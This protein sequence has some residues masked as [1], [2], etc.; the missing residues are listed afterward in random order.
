MTKS[1]VRSEVE[2]L[3]D[4][5]E[6]TA[7]AGY[8]FAIAYICHRDNMVMYQEKLDPADMSRLFTHERL[9]R[10]E[11]TTLLG[12]MVRRPLDLS[13]PTEKQLDALVERTDAL[14]AELH[15]VLTLPM[16]EPIMAQ[17]GSNSREPVG[18]DGAAMREPIFY[19]SESAY[20]FQYRDLLTEKYGTDDPWLVKT[21]GFSIYQAQQAART[22]CRLIDERSTAILSD[23]ERSDIQ[24]EALLS[25]FEFT[26]QEVAENSGLDAATVEAV[27]KALTLQ[28]NNVGFQTVG[29]FN[30][31]AATP[32][33]PTDRGS[34][35]LFQHYAIYEALYESP[36]FWMWND[37]AYRPTAMA[38]RG[39]FAEQFAAARLALVFGSAN[40]HTNVNFF[41][42][43]D[44]AGEADVL[45]TFG[46]RIIIVQ[47]KAKK[48]TLEARKGN[49]G[50]LKADFAAAIQQSYEQGWECASLIV[51]GGCRLEDAN[52]KEITLI[53]APKEVYLFNI[54][55]EHYPALA[56][57]ASQYLTY[58]TTEIIQKPYVMDVF[59]LDALTEM[60]STPLRLLSYVRMRL[61]TLGKVSLSHE[62]TAL[63]LHLRQ[64]MWLDEKYDFV[65]LD[66]SFAADLDTAMTVRR[67]GLP[68]E[69]TPKGILTKMAG[70][71]YER[72]VS[73]IENHA[74]PATLELGFQLLA[75]N[76]EASLNVHRGLTAIN[77]M[78]REDG[79]GHDFSIGLKDN[80]VAIC[81][82]CNAEPS[83]AGMRRLQFHCSKRKYAQRA[84]TVYGISVDPLCNVQFGVTL[85]FPWVESEEMNDLT[86]DMSQGTPAQAGLSALIRQISAQK[87][88]RNDPCPCRSG[89]KF[90]K[91]CMP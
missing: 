89:R 54:L 19:G 23:L 11:I 85:D 40:V 78:T 69:P 3:A 33:L 87:V 26:S 52:G 1:T 67:E 55:S 42:G 73:Q 17:A 83:Q 28:G 91:C 51:E 21:M 25:A 71:L 72:V 56:L 9:M 32:L 43:K 60:L 15:D 79:K 18:W 6:L 57:Q 39:A 38:N 53:H 36:F 31:V 77:R 29:D 27:F 2:V 84:E 62:L 82:H 48:L 88:G 65:H 70:T 75:M 64:N 66:D 86:R 14:M 5:A 16:Q 10:S 30:V 22:L 59:F 80:T 90:K 81:F 74:N 12:L 20:S 37:K 61:T 68:G 4:L 7:T 58:Q 50:K 8:V 63:G 49:D 46:D 35:L 13:T 45:V 76:E 24:P 47:A 44:I 41:K 34:V